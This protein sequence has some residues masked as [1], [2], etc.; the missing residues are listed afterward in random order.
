[1]KIGD[2]VRFLSDTGGGVIAGF[3]GK[4]VLVEDEDGFQIPTP[5][6]EIVV[7]EDAAVDRAK[8][9]IDQQQRKV[10]EGEDKRSIKQR[11]TSASVDDEPINVAWRDVD[12]GIDLNDDPSIDF[13]APVKER[14]GGDELS[15]YLAFTPTD[16]K[17]LSTTH[18]KSYLVNDSNYYI[19]FS[20]AVKDGENWSLRAVGELEPN[21][22]LLIEDFTIADLN[23]MLH[24][25]VQFH[26]YKNKPFKLK[27]TCD[28]QVN[29]DAVK[30]YKLNTFHENVFFEQ[31]ALIYT[32]VEKDKL[33][34]R[35]MFEPLI[36]K[37][38]DKAVEKLKTGY[39]T[40]DCHVD[41][42]VQKGTDELAK[43]YKVEYKKPA[44]QILNNDKI[45][46]DLHSEELLDTT[47][48]MSSADILEYST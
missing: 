7:V 43:R 9:R 16:I 22:K 25:C 8:L 36:K 29:I 26:A 47:A 17:N 21:M 5:A 6:N 4:I 37:T 15:I 12:A 45:I 13:E 1:M 30:F 24:G 38:G 44:K 33:A 42:A 39:V 14:I 46:V 11:L 41:D 2:K 27:P 35:P 23:D 3:K 19:H 40:L 34:L 32:L 10:D 48:G 31:P 18:F 28:I 20:Y